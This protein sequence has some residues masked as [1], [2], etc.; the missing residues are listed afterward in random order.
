MTQIWLQKAPSQDLAQKGPFP[1]VLEVNFNS[2]LEA[3]GNLWEAFGKPLGSF[4]EP[5]EASWKPLES[6]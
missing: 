5:L 4:W 2:Q 1:M 6:F 3:C